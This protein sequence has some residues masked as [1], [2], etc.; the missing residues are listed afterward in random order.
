MYQ[1]PAKRLQAATLARHGCILDDAH[2]FSD[3]GAL[4]ETMSQSPQR[5]SGGRAKRAVRASA[6][7]G[8]AMACIGGTALRPVHAADDFFDGNAQTPSPISDRFALTASF[9]HAVVQTSLRADPPGQ[10]GAGTE[11]SGTHDLAFRPSENDGLAQLMF[12]LRDRNRITVDFLELD[13][14]GT[15]QLSRPIV[16]GTQDFN[17][18]DVMT[19]SLQWRRTGLTWTYAFI[20]NDRFELAAGIGLHVMD[21]DVRGAVPAR[22]AS[23]ETS[24]AGVLPTPAIETAWRITRRFSLTARAQYLKATISGNSGAM[25]D[26]HADVQFRWVPNVSLGVGYSLLRLKL[27]S[28]TTSNAAGSLTLSNPGMVGLRLRGPEAFVRVSF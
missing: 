25:G 14:S 24:V 8:C 11:V 27:N 26:F 6:I 21:L 22:F 23:Y 2:D 3:G 9:Y 19:S 13:Q 1:G 20:Q 17:A 7:L 18:G 28:L 15:L 5:T 4:S 10:P 12:R 16:F